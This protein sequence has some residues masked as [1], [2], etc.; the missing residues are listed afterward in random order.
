MTPKLSTN[1]EAASQIIAT[2]ADT[3]WM[4]AAA[5]GFSSMRSMPHSI[6]SSVDFPAPFGPKRPYTDPSGTC[7]DTRST[8]FCPL[9]VLVRSFVST[10]N[11]IEP[12][13]SLA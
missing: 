13:L 10:M 12:V 1:V 11:P 9:N 5:W 8:A 3:I 7:S 6:L 2:T 4:V